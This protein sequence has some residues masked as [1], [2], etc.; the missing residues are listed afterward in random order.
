MVAS[1]FHTLYARVA[2]VLAVI[3]VVI[4][5]FFIQLMVTSSERYQQEVAQ[6]LNRD[7]A[8]HIVEDKLLFRNQQIDTKALSNLFDMMM[9][10]NPTLEIY[11]LDPDGKILSYSAPPDK[12]RRNR[13]DLEPIK[14]ILSGNKTLPVLG[15][16]PRNTQRSK[17]FSVAPI[18]S[19]G[20]LQGYLYIILASEQYTGI[21]QMLENSYTMQIG[22]GVLVAGLI[23]V[24]LTA[25][26]IFALLTR[27]LR[28]LSS[29]METFKLSG[30]ASAL[31]YQHNPAR[32]DEIDRLSASFESMT[33]RI[34]QQISR[35]RQTDALRRELVANVSHDLRTP[36]ASLQGYLETLTLKQSEL[37]E[38]EKQN[39]I[40]IATR[41]AIHLSEL[42]GD[43]FELAKLEA[44]EIKPHLEP[45][46]LQELVQDVI[47]KFELKARQHNVQLQQ[48]LEKEPPFVLGD[49]GLI[50]RVL[51]NLLDNAL[52]HTPRGGKVTIVLIP[53]DDTVSLQVIDTGCG[54]A[55]QDMP[56]IFD[57]FYAPP[58]PG[59]KGTG[60]G[61]AIARN[62]IELHGSAIR[63][64]SKLNQGTIFSF[65]LPARQAGT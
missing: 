11:L 24:L 15:D 40:D 1:I 47:Q 61:L 49:I 14:I 2:I 9:T 13:V 29:A 3:F 32:A 20:V 65:D 22:T 64:S 23:F 39:Y 46:A 21:A 50:E 16:D 30:R 35:L 58:E 7:L 37:S 38:Q 51:D 62:I 6:R 41:H 18:R 42:I 25:L 52:R 43:L 53:H 59:R 10:I 5:I 4:G 28:R 17:I 8:S 26:L 55:P 45:F 12:V 34:T 48:E 44:N 63:A 27:R 31:E 54:I 33:N 36:L 57:R 60:L 19:N 56:Y